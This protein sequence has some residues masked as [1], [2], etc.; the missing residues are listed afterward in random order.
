MHVAAEQTQVGCA[1]G[2]M[3]FRLHIGQFNACS[4]R[5]A[6]C[7]V[8]FRMNREPTS[9]LRFYIKRRNEMLGT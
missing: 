2:E 5:I 1:C 4:E 8:E 6:G 7:A 9:L 3:P